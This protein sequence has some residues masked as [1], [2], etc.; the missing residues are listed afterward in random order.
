MLRLILEI[1]PDGRI[2][3]PMIVADSLED[4]EIARSVLEPILEKQDLAV[5]IQG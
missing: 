2:S 1:N 5:P 3:G 4:E